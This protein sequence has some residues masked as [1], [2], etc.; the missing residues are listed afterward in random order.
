MLRPHN[1]SPRGRI[2]PE[3]TGETEPGQENAS[4]NPKRGLRA[5][6]TFGF[7]IHE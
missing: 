3:Q 6:R 5:R 1:E 2:A 7:I 4:Q